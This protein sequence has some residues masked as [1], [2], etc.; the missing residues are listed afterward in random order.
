MQI[1]KKSLLLFSTTLSLYFSE[2]AI[3]I[4]CGPEMDPYDN[5]QTYFLPNLEDNSYS[6]FQFIPYQFLYTEQEPVSEAMVNVADWIDH[7]GS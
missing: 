5:Q 7:L 6:A 1:Y 2:I 4:A 3:N